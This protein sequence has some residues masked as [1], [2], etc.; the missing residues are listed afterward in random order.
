MNFISCNPLFAV[1][2]PPIT[3]DFP[4]Y[5]RKNYQAS[6]EMWEKFKEREGSNN[7]IGFI[8]NFKEM[9]ESQNY[10]QGDI[11][12]M[13]SD[14]S[15]HLLMYHLL[16]VKDNYHFSPQTPFVMNGKTIRPDLY[17]W[18]PS[19][20][21]VR[22]IVECDGFEHH[23]SRVAFSRD[24]ARDRALQTQGFQVFRFSGHEIYHDPISASIDLFEYLM[25]LDTWRKEEM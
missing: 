4:D 19:Q 2:T 16:E 25:S 24:R 14:I 8:E 23:T 13:V 21:Q 5:W 7:L 18:V 17:V 10:P 3:P 1:F 9:L 22:I 11:D 12:S 15:R 6:V 20:P